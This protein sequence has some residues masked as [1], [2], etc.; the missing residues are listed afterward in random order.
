MPGQDA[1]LPGWEDAFVAHL[2]LEATL[3]GLD[4][5]TVKIGRAVAAGYTVREAAATAGC[6]LDQANR[7]LR[8]TRAMEVVL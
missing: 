8:V 5:T 1:T 7:K 2:D 3:V 6:S 4:P